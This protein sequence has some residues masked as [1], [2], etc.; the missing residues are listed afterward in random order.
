M[1]AISDP[2]IHTVVMMKSSQAGATEIL[3]NTIG[4]HIHYDPAPILVVQPNLK[5][6]SNWSKTRL[7][8]MLRDTPALKG[9]ISDP[10]SKDSANTIQE[11]VFDGGILAVVT[12]NSPADLASRPIRILLFDEI[13]RYGASAK[14]EGDP[15]DIAMVRGETF[16]NTK[17]VK[18]SSPTIHEI[19]RIEFEFNESDQRYFEVPCPRRGCGKY[20]RL[21]FRDGVKWKKDERGK[22]MD[23]HYQCGYCK[24]RIEEHEKYRMVSRGRWVASRPWVKGIAGFHISALYSP[25]S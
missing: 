23:V 9:K 10:R 21:V 13:D 4:Y 2:A 1:D 15:I 25:W 8:P 18:V 11:K 12:A 17:N 5:M 22:P 16:W 6:A 7:A 20:Q 3:N 24:G 14:E 19:S